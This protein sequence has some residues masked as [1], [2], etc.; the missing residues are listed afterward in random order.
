MAI[1][2]PFRVWQQSTTTGTGTLTLSGSDT[3]K[4]TFNQGFG[5]S[6]TVIYC[7]EG[8]NLFE[9]GVGVFTN[10]GSTL[11]RPSGS[12][13]YSSNAGA[14]VNLPSGT[15]DVF[16][17]FSGEPVYIFSHS[18]T[19][20]VAVT[21]HS[22]RFM[23]TGSGASN[24]NLPALAS[25]PDGFAVTAVNVGSATLTIDGDASELVQMNTGSSATTAAL[26]A[27]KQ[28]TIVK[29]SGSLWRIWAV[30]LA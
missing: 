28:A 2:Y 24:L 27:G 21:D 13:L 22:Y 11:T 10:S 9:I 30:A 3:T 6:A 18:G 4:R 20:T 17:T 26:A 1:P 29:E 12:V 14:L 15:K 19:H 5:T 16:A 23:F 7:I 8:V 25:T